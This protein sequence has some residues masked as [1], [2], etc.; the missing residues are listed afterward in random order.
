MACGRDCGLSGCKRSA[1]LHQTSVMHGWQR[2]GGSPPRTVP[3]PNYPDCARL[4]DE[5]QMEK[6]TQFGCAAAS[7]QTD[8][9]AE[10]NHEGVDYSKRGL[11]FFCP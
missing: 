9:K 10:G 4:F 2:R 11:A 7:S 6:L 8:Q 3:G 5:I 1:A